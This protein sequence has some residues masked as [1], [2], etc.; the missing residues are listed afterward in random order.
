MDPFVGQLQT[1]GFNFA[2][3]GWAKCE[4]QLLAIAEYNTLYSLL[5]TAYG[6][7]GRSTFGLPD[8]RSRSIVGVGRGPGLSPITW[9]ER[10]G[11]ESNSITKNNLPPVDIKAS[12][13]NAS[14]S[15]PTAGSVPATTGAL[16]GRAF[17]ATDG[18]NT[19]TPDVTLYN[20]GGTSVAMNNMH[21][22]LG[23]LTCICLNG[24]YPSR[25]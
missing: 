2:P 17:A 15:A 1:F 13:A 21:P 8:L 5:G 3:R 24:I 7:D 19:E 6:G 23:I 20:A 25:S 22:S 14:Q 16:S 10:F 11:N 9:G 18:Y 12:S 4:G